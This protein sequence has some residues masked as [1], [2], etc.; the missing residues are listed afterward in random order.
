MAREL[1]LDL[2]A[3]V[4]TGPDG[5]IVKADVVTAAASPTRT[6][7]RPAA[8]AVA[9]ASTQGADVV[10]EPTRVERIVADRMVASTTTIPHYTVSVEIDV[11]AAL[12]FREDFKAL[13]DAQTA[14]VP[15]INDLVVKAVALALRDHPR[16]NSAWTEAG[17]VE[18]A[19]INVGVAVA[20]EDGGLV[21]PVIRNADRL[22]LGA[23]ADTAFGLVSRARTGRGTPEDFAG[24]TFTVSNLGMF[25]MAAFTSIVPVGQG[26]ILS[27]G[28]ASR[29]YDEVDGHPVARMRL[30]A[31]LSSDHRVIYGAHAAAFL[32]RLRA[33]LEHPAGLAL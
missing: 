23:L 28:G 10:R 21:V 25:A 16:V 9:T 19:A 6:A 4:A 24:A 29:H 14:R 27:V 2:S 12:A 26:A 13:I 7:G 30:T 1:N 20:T 15:S 32:A 22:P 11:T 8:P 3:I 33:L 5:R 17:V 18:P 31:T